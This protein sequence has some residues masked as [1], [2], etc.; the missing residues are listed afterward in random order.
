MGC[1]SEGCFP[2][3]GGL[4]GCKHKEPGDCRGGLERGISNW[5]N[6]LSEGLGARAVV[7]GGAA[8]WRFRGMW[9]IGIDFVMKDPWTEIEEFC[10]YLIIA[11]ESQRSFFFFKLTCIP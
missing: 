10:L 1:N 4:E 6:S 3:R 9:E 11:L 8:R 7:P 2:R 5:E